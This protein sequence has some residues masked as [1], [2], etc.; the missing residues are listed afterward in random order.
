MYGF[1][2]T[3]HFNNYNIIKKCIDLLFNVIPDE[4]FVVLYVNETKCN[5]V[6]NIKNDYLSY[7]KKFDVIYI[8]NQENNGGL[9]GTWNK[10]INYLLNKKDFSCKVITILGH[11]TYVNKEIKY[12]LDAALNAENNKNLKY[13]GPLYKNFKGKTDELWQDELYYKN[14]SKKFII[15]SLFTFPVHSLIKNKLNKDCYFDA[16]RFPFGYNDIDWY[17][18]FIKIGGN[19]IIIPQCIID[20]KYERTWM[21]YDKNLRNYR[22]SNNG[23]NSN[24]GNS[25]NEHSV[26]DNEIEKLFLVNK[27]DELN[28]DWR[29][30]LIK[31]IDLHNKGIRTQKDALNH[32]LSIGIHQKRTF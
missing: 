5:K 13:F 17:N 11:D 22:I 30:Y 8:D 10:G 9:T 27:I 25:A 26:S 14:Y 1:I 6:L 28:F 4:S 24:N 29:S 16:D 20:H 15:G 2:V 32:Y 21:A 3:T 7:N 31:N 19:A 23:N 18:R 12:L